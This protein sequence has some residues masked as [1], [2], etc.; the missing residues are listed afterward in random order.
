ML[1]EQ[2]TPENE[3]PAQALAVCGPVPL[4]EGKARALR[5]HSPAHRQV[6]DPR[7]YGRPE[8]VLVTDVEF[9]RDQWGN[10]VRVD[11]QYSPEGARAIYGLNTD[12]G[13]WSIY[14]D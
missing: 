4:A 5:D 13:E 2:V 11:F 9:G 3:A 8:Q 10:D 14:C 6:W 1:W 12:T 7:P